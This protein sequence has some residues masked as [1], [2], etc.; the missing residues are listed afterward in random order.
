MALREAV[1]GFD[2]KHVGDLKASL[3]AGLD[4]AKVDLLL[5]WCGNAEARVQVAASWLVRGVLEKGVALSKPQLL[6]YCT[7]AKTFTYWETQLHF[8]QSVQFFEPDR[9]V[10]KVAFEVA[11]LLRGAKKTLVSVWAMDA[12]VRL[13]M[14]KGDVDAARKLINEAQ[15]HKAASYRARARNLVKAFPVLE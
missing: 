9:E 8:L 14:F 3:D 12:C 11:D 10:A 13:Q 2:G 5:D 4:A 7:V 1:F 6:R 15:A